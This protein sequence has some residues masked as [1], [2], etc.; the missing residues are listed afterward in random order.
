[1]GSH[2]GRWLAMPMPMGAWLRTAEQSQAM[3]SWSMVG[4]FRGHPRSR[5]LSHSQPQR[6]SMLQQ[7]MGWRR[8]CGSVI[9]LQRCLSLSWMQQLSFRTTSQSL[10]SP[11]TTSSMR[12]RST[13]MCATT[14][15]IGWLKMVPC[16]SFIAW[17]QTW[18]LTCLQKL[19]PCRRSNTLQSVSDFAWFEG[20]C[21]ISYLYLSPCVYLC[22]LILSV[23]CANPHKVIWL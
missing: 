15:F 1:M 18:S 22:Y 21:W 12:T 9:C 10:C 5:R 14:S 13:L 23:V 3:P 19:S 16:A 7:R 8:P 20:E 11:A 17:Q 6:V 2:A 4:P